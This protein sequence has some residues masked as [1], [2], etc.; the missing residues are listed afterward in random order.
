MRWCKQKT[1]C[2]NYV[3]LL[4][5]LLIA[6]VYYKSTYTFFSNATNK[7]VRL[8]KSH[9][10]GPGPS[11][12]SAITA[13]TQNNFSRYLRSKLSWI[14]ALYV[15]WTFVL[16]NKRC[17]AMAV[18]DG[19]IVRAT[20]VSVRMTKCS[21]LYG[22]RDKWCRTRKLAALGQL[23]QNGSF[24]SHKSIKVMINSASVCVL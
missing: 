10:L 19:S 11:L 6:R 8:T 21:H 20:L 16:A 13:H 12:I 14:L 1:T 2:P 9:Y 4:S 24:R 22:P 5:L 18:K 17:C 15:N 3:A 7:N 23:K